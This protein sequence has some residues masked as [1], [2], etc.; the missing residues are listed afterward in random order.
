[1]AVQDDPE[2]LESLQK[3][4]AT[5]SDIKAIA[6][7]QQKLYTSLNELNASHR[8]VFEHVRGLTD[9]HNRHQASTDTLVRARDNFESLLRSLDQAHRQTQDEVRQAINSLN[10]IQQE[11]RKIQ[12]LE[13]RIQ[14]L[15]Y[16][17]RQLQQEGRKDDRKDDEQDQR[18]RRLEGRR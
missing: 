3:I 5:R 8:N 13:D 1:M 9:S 7:Y 12:Q 17:I 10:Y 4:F 16:D 15:E 2:F 18:L 6:D 14:R 11:I